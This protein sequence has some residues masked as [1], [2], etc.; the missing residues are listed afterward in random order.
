MT[1]IQ[2]KDAPTTVAGPVQL[3]LPADPAM[4]RVVR[5]TASAL[6]SLCEFSIDDIDD[7]KIA[8]SEVLIALVEH[9]AGHPVDITFEVDERGFQI[10]ATTEAPDFRAD[11]P[12]LHLCRTVLASVC[13]FHDVRR[14]GDLARI[15]AVVARLPQADDRDR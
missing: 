1:D 3:R 4:P 2:H 6:A 11:D 15:R 5:L 9:G 14:V 12:D 13:S 8:V 10:D 7:V